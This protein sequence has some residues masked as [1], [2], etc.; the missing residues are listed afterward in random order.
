MVR[1]VTGRKRDDAI[2]EQFARRDAVTGLP[3]RLAFE[4]RLRDVVLKAGREH[5]RL[6]LVIFDVHN[7][8]SL[9]DSIVLST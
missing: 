9:T 6:G 1:D 5:E 3:N 8:G 4:E 7:A 2:A